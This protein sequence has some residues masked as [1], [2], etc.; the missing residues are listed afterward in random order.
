MMA[1]TG[2]IETVL[3]RAAVHQTILKTSFWQWRPALGLWSSALG[4]R[5][6]P[7]GIEK[8]LLGNDAPHWAYEQLCFGEQVFAKQYWKLFFGHDAP[9][10]AYEQLCLNKPAFDKQYW[11]S[12]FGN[13]ARHWHWAYE[14]CASGKRCSPNSIEQLGFGNDAPHWAYEICALENRC[15]PNSIEN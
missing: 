6:S 10:W 14:D 5:C 15:A 7:N 2:L 12:L 9:H 11:K 8:Q 3:W 4:N 1:R 13:D